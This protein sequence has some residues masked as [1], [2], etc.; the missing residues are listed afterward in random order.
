MCMCVGIVWRCI[1]AR[2]VSD[3]QR[4]GPSE[5]IGW[6][7]E[8]PGR[9]KRLPQRL[10]ARPCS[11]WATRR[12]ARMRM[13][14]LADAAAQPCWRCANFRL[15]D[16]VAQ[17]CCARRS[18]GEHFNVS[19][20]GELQGRNLRASAWLQRNSDRCAMRMVRALCRMA[21]SNAI[22]AQQTYANAP[23]W[24]DARRRWRAEARAGLLS[25][26]RWR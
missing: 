16:R 3:R 6:L 2:C 15:S 20:S 7:P 21:L 24:R 25:R 22:G 18:F 8:T 5:R 19:A 26:N 10:A 13:P 1:P 12:L 17:R 14:L 23:R 11:C 4:S 9:A